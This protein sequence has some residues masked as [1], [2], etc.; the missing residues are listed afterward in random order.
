[1]SRAVFLI[2]IVTAF[3]A[4][5]LI[6]LDWAA[7]RPTKLWPALWPIVSIVW[8]LSAEGWRSAAKMWRARFEQGWGNNS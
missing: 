2:F 4:A 7:E 8:C 1:M 5:L 6:G 3:V